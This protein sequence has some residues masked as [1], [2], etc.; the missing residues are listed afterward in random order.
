MQKEDRNKLFL[1]LITT[2]DKGWSY[3]NEYNALL[4]DY[5]GVILYQS[6]SQFIHKIGEN[7]GITI[8]ELSK[9]YDKSV[10]ACS[11]LMRRM[12]KKGWLYQERNQN[13]NRE[14][15]LYLSKEGEVVYKN[16]SRF[17]ETCY[18]RTL[19]ML[20]NFDEEQIKN[21][22]AIQK[23]LNRAFA[24]DVEESRL[25]FSYVGKRII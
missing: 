9:I 1:E 3:V 15:Q 23:Q 19:N 13:N 24:I 6:E 16:H 7:P 10:S 17:E 2:F 4:H 11:Q 25:I 12:K 18:N 20:D 8:T 5:D 22:I 14:Y 21:Y